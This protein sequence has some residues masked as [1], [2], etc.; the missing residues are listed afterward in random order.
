VVSGTWP[1]L[2]VVAVLS[3]IV[4]IGGRWCFSSEVAQ[5]LAPRWKWVGDPVVATFVAIVILLVLL[6]THNLGFVPRN[7]GFDTDGHLEYIQY[8]QEHSSLPLADAGWE[9]HQPPLYYLLGA[10]VLNLLKSSATSFDGLAQLRLLSLVLGI[11]HLVVVFASVRLL[12]PADRAKQCVGLALAGFLPMQLYLTHYITNELLAAVLMSATIY[13]ILRMLRSEEIHWGS[14]SL[15]GLALGL[16]LLTKVTA[17]ILVPFALVAVLYCAIRSRR[18]VAQRWL[19]PLMAVVICLSLCGWHYHRVWKQFGHPLFASTR[20]AFGVSWWQDPGYRTS[21]YFAGFGRA[22]TDPFFSGLASFWDGAYSTLWGDGLCGGAAAWIFRPPWNF[23]LMTVGFVLALMPTVLILTGAWSLGF[24]AVRRLDPVHVALVGFCLAV[25][26]ALIHLN[27]TVPSY[28]VA[29]SF[30]GLSALVPLC[31][32]AGVGWEIFERRGRAVSRIA[33]TVLVAWGLT[34][35]LSFWID[36]K[37]ATTQALVGRALMRVGNDAGAV[38][39]LKAA[40]A[41]DAVHV[42]AR[43]F[44]IVALLRQGQVSEAHHLAARAIEE[45]PNQAIGH[46][47]LAAVVEIQGR[48]DEAVVHTTRAVALAP[49]NPEA[50]LRLASRLFKLRRLAESVTATRE[51]LRLSPADPE[52]HLILGCA[53][54]AEGR[55]PTSSLAL[56][57]EQPLFTVTATNLAGAP[58][59]LTAHAIDHLRLCLKLSPNFADAMNNLAWI[60]ATYPQSELRTGREAVELAKKA[61]SLTSYRNAD[62]LTTLAAALAETGEFDLAKETAE[63]ARSIIPESSRE[64]QSMNQRLMQ[65]FAEKQPYRQQLN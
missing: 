36:S 4:L 6:V 57:G 62:M 34:S 51:A 30:Y 20:W 48:V 65:L 3:L 58:E 2:A 12:F 45:L 7:V 11:I 63:K 53:L 42:G 1:T 13:L 33:G 43:S 37:S 46:L 26:V 24:N 17:V 16:A 38:A 44:L 10:V 39:H 15:V 56:G 60:L 41:V 29:K 18:A 8:I 23:N 32:F 27:L 25:L 54:A 59:V 61:C 35:Y 28:A 64:A 5:G 9:M 52:L 14:V 47:D 19:M 21:Q 50:R 49:D 31:A 55:K 40:L 22:L